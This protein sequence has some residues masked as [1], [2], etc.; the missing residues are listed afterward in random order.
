MFFSMVF[1]VQQIDKEVNMYIFIFTVSTLSTYVHLNP[2]VEDEDPWRCPKFGTLAIRPWY[3]SKK[4]RIVGSK[5]VG[6][7]PIIIPRYCF[8]LL[9]EKGSVPTHAKRAEFCYINWKTC[10]TIAGVAVFGINP[11][12]SSTKKQSIW[13]A[14]KISGF[15]GVKKHNPVFN[16]RKYIGFTGFISPYL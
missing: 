10:Y 1:D 16:G 12:A 11:S 9:G 7:I 14:V 6:E 3:W 13:E 5:N 4:A 2:Q 15:C 8:F